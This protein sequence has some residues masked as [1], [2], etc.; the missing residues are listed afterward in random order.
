[1]YPNLDRR[2]EVARVD[3]PSERDAQIADSP[4]HVGCREAAR[5][6]AV[7]TVP[8]LVDQLEGDHIALT[9]HHA[10]AERL[11]RG[12]RRKVEAGR[13]QLRERFASRR[14]QRVAALEPWQR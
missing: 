9:S 5:V 13:L 6:G 3:H 14:A 12:T 2:L 11:A 4:T 7:V 10:R 8:P 1:M